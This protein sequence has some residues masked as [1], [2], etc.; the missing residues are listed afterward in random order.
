MHQ[1]RFTLDIK[2]NFISERMMKYWNRLPREVVESLSLELVK[3]TVD[4]VLRSMV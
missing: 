1:G 2:R 3:E 4:V